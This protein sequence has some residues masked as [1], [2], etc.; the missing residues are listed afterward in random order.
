MGNF[1]LNTNKGSHSKYKIGKHTYGSINIYGEHLLDE[2]IIGSFCSIGSDVSALIKGWSH[3]VDWFTTYPFEAFPNKWS[4]ASN[5]IKYPRFK[6]SIKIGND[7]WIG[8]GVTIF[9]GVEIGDGAVIGTNAVVSKNVPPYTVAV[10]NS[11]RFIKTRF[12]EEDINFLLNLKWWDWSD[13]KINEHLTIINSGDIS[14]LKTL[15]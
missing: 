15:K 3:N 4:N 1:L 6:T 2:M 13:E 5:I 7:V 9:S 11:I 10:G 14:Q 8:Q 12:S